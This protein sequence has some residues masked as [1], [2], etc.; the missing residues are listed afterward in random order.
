MLNLRIGE[1]TVN[2]VDKWKYLGTVF[3]YSMK[4]HKH[5]EH[6]AT[7][8]KYLIYVFA[9]LS[10]FMQTKTLMTIYY[11]LFHSYINYGIIAWGGAYGNSLDVL[12]KNTK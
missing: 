11:A 8:T 12:Q 9:K 6:I 2:R 4:W 7:K 1:Q 3:V 5:I 10:K